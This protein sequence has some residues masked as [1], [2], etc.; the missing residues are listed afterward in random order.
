MAH[1]YKRNLESR[2]PPVKTSSV[3]GLLFLGGHLPTFPSFQTGA[4]WVDRLGSTQN[5]PT[6]KSAPA[7][8]AKKKFVI[9]RI[10]R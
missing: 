1:Q 8:L 3:Y 2:P 10:F 7:R 9:V 4:S 6:H 5:I